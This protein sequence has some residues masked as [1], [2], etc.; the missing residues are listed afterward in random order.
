MVHGIKGNSCGEGFVGEAAMTNPTYAAVSE[1]LS[2]ARSLGAKAG[3]PA[4]SIRIH[5]RDGYRWLLDSLRRLFRMGERSGDCFARSAGIELEIDLH[6]PHHTDEIQIQ[7]E[8]VLDAVNR[9]P[10]T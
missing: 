9:E 5:V 10:S 6:E 3:P 7:E 1:H 2:D 8:P 4:G